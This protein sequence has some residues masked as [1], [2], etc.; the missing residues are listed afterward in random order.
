M[1]GK[2]QIEDFIRGILTIWYTRP[3]RSA[4]PC[5]NPAAKSGSGQ[6]VVQVGDASVEYV[7]GKTI[8]QDVINEARTDSSKSALRYLSS[9][10]T[11]RIGRILAKTKRQGSLAL[12]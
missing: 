6:R 10:E 5:K 1:R 4:N 2:L 9:S 3:N 12:R 11:F 8:Q 7:K